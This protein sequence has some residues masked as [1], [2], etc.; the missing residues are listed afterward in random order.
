MCY[1]TTMGFLNLGQYDCIGRPADIGQMFVNL[2]LI[3]IILVILYWLTK[4][5]RVGD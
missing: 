4:N 3:I 5:E 2:G 1:E